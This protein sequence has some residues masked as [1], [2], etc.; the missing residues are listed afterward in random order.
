MQTIDEEADEFLSVLLLVACEHL[1]HLADCLLEVIGFDYVVIFPSKFHQFAKDF[2]EPPFVSE[3]IV[4]I[5]LLKMDLAF[6]E[7]IVEVAQ[8]N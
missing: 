2:G 6:N 8:I 3:R 5:Q 7:E 4:Y 1:V